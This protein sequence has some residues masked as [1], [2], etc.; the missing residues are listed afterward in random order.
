[1]SLVVSYLADHRVFEKQRIDESDHLHLVVGTSLAAMI[2]ESTATGEQHAA[3]ENVNPPA[4][5]GA[6]SQ[7][8]VTQS[9]PAYV[10]QTWRRD[11]WPYADTLVSSD[12]PY[13]PSRSAASHQRASTGKTV[14]PKP[15][16]SWPHRCSEVLLDVGTSIVCLLACLVMVPFALAANVIVAVVSAV[17]G[18]ICRPFLMCYMCWAH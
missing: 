6:A 2:R 10:S 7:P 17:L 1:M 4:Y 14:A 8:P 13:D 16:Q 11:N 5:M 15:K 3:S 18:I 12:H 9:A